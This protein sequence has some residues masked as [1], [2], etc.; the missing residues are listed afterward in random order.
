MRAPS[1]KSLPILPALA[2]MMG[3]Q[4]L[5]IIALLAP[6][7]M[8]P[9]IGLDAATLGLYATAACVVGMMTTFPAGM[10]VGRYGSFR[11]ASVCAAI[12][13][14]A[15]ALSTFAGASALL[16]V[17]GVILGCAYGP[18]TPASSAVLS[19][20]TPAALRPLVFSTR[21]S[22]NQI[23]AMLGSLVLPSLAAADPVYGYIAIMI[24][25][26][27]AMIAFELL[28]PTYDPLVRGAA[29][30]QLRD[31]LNVLSESRDLRRLAAVS[32]PYS[33]LQVVLNTFL[34]IYGVGTLGLDLVGAGLLLATA[35]G[36]G[37][38]GRLGFGFVATRY[39]SAWK[40]LI[41]LGLGM[42]LSAGLVALADGSWSWPLL[43]TVAFFFGVTASGW[44]GVFLAEVARLAPEGRIAEATG[45]ALVPGF[46]GL[47]VG[48]LLVAATA[49]VIGL[50]GAYAVL[51]AGSLAAV[52]LLVGRHR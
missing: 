33:A 26:L 8:A 34:V 44:N 48:P 24:A 3:L 51:G 45:A 22:G 18:E 29:S 28:R 21:Q 13:L 47:V 10:L 19:R 6:G 5:T 25:A 15:T 32:M 37:L 20:I 23:G 42:G 1:P 17:A 2:A 43:L 16:I 50:S 46:F 35:Q 38:I 36:G 52:L 49:G 12:V 7:V 9:R 27:V 31:A 14:C 4:M 39:I 11:M 40:T 30:V 41:G